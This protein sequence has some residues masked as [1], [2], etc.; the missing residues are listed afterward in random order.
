MNH[1]FVKKYKVTE[2]YNNNFSDGIAEIYNNDL[3][4][5]NYIVIKKQL[6]TCILHVT[7]SGYTNV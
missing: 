5:G 1:R 6:E 2:I 4:D 3:S 7:F